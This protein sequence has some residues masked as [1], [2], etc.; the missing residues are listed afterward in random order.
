[1]YKEVLQI[2]LHFNILKNMTNFLKKRIAEGWGS[3]GDKVKFA[4]PI[5]FALMFIVAAVFW[6]KYYDIDSSTKSCLTNTNCSA[7]EITDL[8]ICTWS[9][10]NK[11]TY[12]SVKNEYTLW[13][14][15]EIG[16]NNYR[17]TWWN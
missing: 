5:M 7:E 11:I 13:C 15:D 14:G 16:Y 12:N 8:N 1:M 3:I 2:I 4:F 6:W 9:P 10:D 17:L